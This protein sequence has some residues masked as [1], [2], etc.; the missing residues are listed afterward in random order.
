VAEGE[1]VVTRAH[2]SSPLRFDTLDQVVDAVRA[3]GGRLSTPRRLVLEALF[4]EAEP[5]PAEAIARRLAL[6]PTSVYRNLESLEALGAV[7]H[8]HLG[9]GPGLY[10]LVGRGTREYLVC[11]ICDGMTVVEPGRLDGV[12]ELVRREFDFDARFGHFPILGI[13]AACRGNLA[14]MEEHEH[15]HPH[16]HEHE[17]DGETHSHAHTT[18]DHEHVEHEHEHS[19]GDVTHSHPHVHEDGLEHDHTHDHD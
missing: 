2:H 18:H 7:R 4:A 9:H 11:E 14:S 3:G 16:S 19:H 5:V 17:H 10:T 15:S 1:R 8:V 13:C 12:R 6:D